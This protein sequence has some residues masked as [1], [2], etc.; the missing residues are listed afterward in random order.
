MKYF[1]V[2]VVLAAIALVCSVIIAAMNLVTA[3]VIAS[4]KAETELQTIQ[5]IF[6]DYSDEKSA[7]E[8]N[9]SDSITKKILASDKDGNVLGYVYIVTGKNAYG[10]ITLMVAIKDGNLYQVEFVT[11]EQSFASTVEKHLHSSYPSS[12]KKSIEVGFTSDSGLSKVGPLSEDNVDNVD[13]KCGATYGAK[14]VK[15]LIKVAFDNYNKTN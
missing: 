1:K 5:K 7:K 9:V 3:P 14:L 11:N 8:E 10:T 2:S 4:N 12:D 13:V 6:A 15:E